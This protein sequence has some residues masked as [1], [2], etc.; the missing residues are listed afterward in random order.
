MVGKQKWL[1][2]VWITGVGGT[3]AGEGKETDYYVWI[4]GGEVG[5]RLNY[6]L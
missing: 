6:K 5:N 1:L 3:V 2:N 4:T